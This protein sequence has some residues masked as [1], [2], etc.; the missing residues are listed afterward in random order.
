[1]AHEN[2]PRAPTPPPHIVGF[3]AD[4]LPY[5]ESSDDDTLAPLPRI[6]SKRKGKK[7]INIETRMEPSKHRPSFFR[8]AIDS[9]T[10]KA[11]SVPPPAHSL[12][13]R[14]H[15][16]EAA[17]IPSSRLPPEQHFG[18][19][20]T[21]NPR[22]SPRVDRHTFEEPV[23]ELSIQEIENGYSVESRHVTFQEPTEFTEGSG[24]GHEG[25]W[26]TEGVGNAW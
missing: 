25:G 15:N 21:T 18:T 12:E 23:S 1:M 17:I 8:E 3:W 13:R 5:P 22:Q 24:R 20:L 6:K 14:Y 10:E 19:A 9:V 7:K 2:I 26:D 16:E 11:A 4:A